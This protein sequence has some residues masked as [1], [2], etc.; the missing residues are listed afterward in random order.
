MGDAIGHSTTFLTLPSEIKNGAL[1]YISSFILSILIYNINIY[2]FDFVP[3]S[4]NLII[5]LIIIGFG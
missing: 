3:E 5:K 2:Q 1:E 4:L